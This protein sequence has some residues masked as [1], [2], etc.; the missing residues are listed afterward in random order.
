MEVGILLGDVSS[1]M[2]PREHFDSLLRQVE[3]AQRNGIT[4]ITI[5]QHFLYGDLRWLQPV[6]VLARLAG[7]TD[8]DVKLGI[9]I[10]VVPFYNPVILA[11][12]IAT[13]DVVT[14]GRLRFGVG[15]GYR[16]E[17]FKLLG[18]PYEERVGRT[19]EAL[20]LM[21]R[22][23]T[24]DRVDFHG[25]HFTLED[26]RPHISPIQTP[27]PPIWM[28][29]HSRAGA[30]RAGRF[31]DAMIIP[32]ETEIDEIQARLEIMKEGF[33]ERGVPFTHQ[34][35]R[36]N[37]MVADTHDEAVD[38]FIEVSQDRYLAYAEKELDILDADALRKDFIGT[39]GAHAVLGS[40]DEVVEE[41]RRVA[42]E[43]PVDPIIV[44]PQW[45]TMS[46]DDVVDYLDTLGRQVIPAIRETD[47]LP[48]A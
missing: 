30:R 35:L 48:L 6:P 17:E 16:S 18:I 41:L 45:P 19:E 31:G 37:V 22:I 24:E 26:G 42:R 32:P 44:K 9:T 23:W 1:S 28:G 21:R 43:I 11:E 33:A 14:G 40:H 20:E 3:A 7:E 36:R 38:R 12:E 27:H 10:T 47:P 5:G 8:D 39:V 34:P 29:A 15:L 4:Y 46:P 2:D 13:L 25:Q